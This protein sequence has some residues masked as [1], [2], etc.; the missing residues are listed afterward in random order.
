[1]NSMPADFFSGL[2]PLSV[3][4]LVEKLQ[5][6][7]SETLDGLG[8]GRQTRLINIQQAERVFEAPARP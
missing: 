3:G 7:G 2:P 8:T 5:R 4:M 6:G 1:M